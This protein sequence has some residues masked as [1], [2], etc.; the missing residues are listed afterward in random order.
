MEHLQSRLRRRINSFLIFFVTVFF[1]VLFFFHRLLH[2]NPPLQLL[3]RVLRLIDSVKAPQARAC[4]VWLVAT[5]V[6]KV[7][8]FY[9]SVYLRKMRICGKRKIADMT[10]YNL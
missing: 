7:S 1:Q 9:I 8:T 10:G 3:T 6:D 4:V 2:T 5:H